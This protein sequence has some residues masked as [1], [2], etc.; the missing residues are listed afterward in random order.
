[1]VALLYKQKRGRLPSLPKLRE[2]PPRYVEPDSIPLN[3]SGERAVSAPHISSVEAVDLSQVRSTT[4]GLVIEEMRGGA[5]GEAPQEVAEQQEISAR[6]AA[7]AFQSPSME[8]AGEA[9]DEAAGLAA[10]GEGGVADDLKV[11]EGI[12]PAIARILSENGIR[13]FRQLA[14]AKV[15]R[16]T[17]ILTA[18]NLNRLADPATWAEQAA[19]AADGKWEALETFKGTLKAGRRRKA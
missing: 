14:S 16:L 13:S 1:V 4:S 7:S 6:Q 9:A 17:E 5:D 10:A 11:I 2:E 8:L 15:E 19:M 12:G 18:A 3:M